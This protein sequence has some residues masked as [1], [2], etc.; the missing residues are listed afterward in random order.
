MRISECALGRCI[1]RRK[2]P[3]TMSMLEQRRQCFQARARLGLLEY[4]VKLFAQPARIE[5]AERAGSQGLP[6]CALGPGLP[7]QAKALSEAH[8]AQH[9]ARIIQET[10]LMQHA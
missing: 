1:S 8:P 6:R 5:P 7:A 4:P 2:T 3:T 10:A 9:A